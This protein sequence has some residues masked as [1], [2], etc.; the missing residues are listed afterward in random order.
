MILMPSKR[1]ASARSTARG[2]A[3]RPGLAEAGRD[4]D[5]AADAGFSALADEP[6]DLGGRGADDA[7]VRGLG[8]RGDAREA[9]DAHHGFDRGCDGIDDAAEAAADKVGED[10]AADA[11]RVRADPDQGDPLGLEDLVE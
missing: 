5:Q 11:L 4:D 8:E 3:G 2:Q 7:E 9:G 1:R 10:P 6:R